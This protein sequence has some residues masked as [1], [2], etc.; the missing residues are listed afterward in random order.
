MSEFKRD[1]SELGCLWIKS[2]PRGE[3]WTGTINGQ[4]IVVFKNDRKT[5]GSQ[6]PDYR[7]LKAK[8]REREE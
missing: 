4:G 2:G 7:I 5:P 1:E 6:Q 3:F 8:P